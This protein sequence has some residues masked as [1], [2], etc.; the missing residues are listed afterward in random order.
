MNSIENLVSKIQE[1]PSM[2]LGRKTVSCLK[3]FLDGWYLRDPD[4]VLD[5]DL[6]GRYQE[7][8]EDRYNKK[9]THSWDRI[10]LFYS[11]DEYDA[12]QLFFETFNEFLSISEPE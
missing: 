10:L 11:E 7:W 9:D 5:S 6:M 4:N 8:I 3:A 2:Y 1:R 12:L